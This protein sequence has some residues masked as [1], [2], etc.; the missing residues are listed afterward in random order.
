VA[1]KLNW[2]LCTTKIENICSEIRAARRCK[3]PFGDIGQQTQVSIIMEE[4]EEDF[5]EEPW[6]P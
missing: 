4:E 6:R 5:D 2:V 3:R 1:F